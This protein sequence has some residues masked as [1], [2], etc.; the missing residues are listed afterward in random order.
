MS[1]VAIIPA[2]GGS[3]RIP[4]KNIRQFHGKPIIAY[5]I[6]T[7]ARSGLFDG[8]YV[9]TE[10]AEIAE[11]AN[12]MGAEVIGRP[13]ELAEIDTPDCGTQEVARHALTV[14]G[15]VESA[16]CIY[17]CAP[18][19]S[20]DDLRFGLGVL[21]RGRNDFVYVPGWY[22]WGS[23]AAFLDR[24]GFEN[25]LAVVVPRY[26][27]INTEDDWRHAEELYAELHKE[28]AVWQPA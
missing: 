13:P 24:M 28:E 17:P 23:S 3:K 1:A 7:A 16:C 4:R 9:S 15:G 12:L 10:D 18:L 26:V 22:Y 5:S 20:T 25:S 8:I 21:R 6:E 2:R 11:V 19:M 27:D 14:L